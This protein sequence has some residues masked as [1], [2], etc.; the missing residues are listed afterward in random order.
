M[1][2]SKKDAE[3]AERILRPEYLSQEILG[4]LNDYNAV[5]QAP[6]PLS[7][8]I[9]VNA[10]MVPIGVPLPWLTGEIPF[11]FV[12]LDGGVVSRTQYVLLFNL[13]GT[14]FG[15]GDGSTTFGLPD[16]RGRVLVGLGT[17]ADVDTLGETEGVAVG[18]RRPKHSHTVN[19]TAHT[20]TN[21]AHSHTAPRATVAGGAATSF[22]P[23]D[24]PSG[25][26]STNTQ[27]ITINSASTGITVGVTTAPVDGPA[28]MVVHYIT[29]Y[30]ISGGGDQP[31]QELQAPVERR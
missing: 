22:L 5:N 6:V 14:T 12:L 2:W 19:E 7:N 15:A 24:T 11:G 30:A 20:H 16:M 27:S 13:W 21:V 23:G 1:L 28:Y 9:G 10:A 31:V 18:S 3:L 29:R 8:I 17:H 4:Y 25:T 26:L